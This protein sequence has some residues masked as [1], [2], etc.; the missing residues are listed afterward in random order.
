MGNSL[1]FKQVCKCSSAAWLA[2]IKSIDRRVFRGPLSGTDRHS[3][4]HPYQNIEVPLRDYSR[5]RLQNLRTTPSIRTIRSLPVYYSIRDDFVPCAR[6]QV[7][8]FDHKGPY[9][10]VPCESLQTALA[11]TSSQS[12]ARHPLKIKASK[13]VE[14][15]YVIA[16]LIPHNAFLFSGLAIDC[17]SIDVGFRI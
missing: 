7:R 2:V 17:S 5:T 3:H 1:K 10:L 11:P 14:V 16:T 13:R 9:Y 8:I 15:S 12:A 4:R 6:Q